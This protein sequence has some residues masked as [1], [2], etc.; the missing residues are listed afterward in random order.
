MHHSTI[1]K[2]MTKTLD[3][4]SASKIF[5]WIYNEY[6][7]FSNLSLNKSLKL[8]LKLKIKILHATHYFSFLFSH[9]SKL[10]I[11]EM[12]CSSHL[13]ILSLFFSLSSKQNLLRRKSQQPFLQFKSALSITQRYMKR[14]RWRRMSTKMKSSKSISMMKQGGL[15]GTGWGC[16][17]WR[18]RITSRPKSAT[19]RVK[20][21]PTKSSMIPGSGWGR[22]K[23][24]WLSELKKSWVIWV[25]YFLN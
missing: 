16:S 17:T 5:S 25:N 10:F 21:G 6:Y 11:K 23:W 24:Q 14:R 19:L 7:V 2:L 9:S 3:W 18:T 15:T 12:I 1:L 20:T 4:V 13:L 8:K 22:Q